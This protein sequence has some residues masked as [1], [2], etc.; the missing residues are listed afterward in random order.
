[1]AFKK[2]DGEVFYADIASSV[3]NLGGQQ[4]IQ[5]I[6]RDIT[7]RKQAELALADS[8]R[9]L[10][11]IIEF[12]PDPTFVIDTDGRVIAWNRAIE[13][14]TGIGK[15]EIVGKGNHAY[16]VPF[17]G[18]PRPTLVDLVL[19]GDDHWERDYLKIEKVDGVPIA[20]ESYHPQMGAGG[21]FFAGSA[22][23]L[24]DVQGNVVGAIESIRDIT[25]SKRLEKEREKLIAEL[26]S[27]VAKVRTLSGMLPICSACKKI[28][29][30]RGYWKQ[31]ESYISEHSE[32]EFSHSICPTCVKKLYP[33]LDI[34]PD[35]A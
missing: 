5:G 29:D 12:L 4:L 8:E 28:R 6:V 1:L 16:A 20:C 14:L 31:I 35:H 19:E 18:E 3:F 25:A 30:D 9:R 2:K 26:R 34:D 11:D 10:S 24:Y 27:A 32:A 22:A 23:R 15:T 13:R 21:R 33:D 7:E 17:Y